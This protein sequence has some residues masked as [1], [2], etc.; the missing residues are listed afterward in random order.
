MSSLGRSHLGE[1]DLVPTLDK[2]FLSGA[3]PSRIRATR[4]RLYDF[5]D[6]FND[7]DHAAYAN[8]AVRQC[9]PG[10]G[11][12]TF[13]DDG[14][15]SFSV[16]G[17][18][19]VWPTPNTTGSG[20]NGDEAPRG[21]ASVARLAGKML[22]AKLRNT[23]SAT[24]TWDFGFFNNTT[25]A[26]GN[27][28][29][30][31]GSW[32]GNPAIWEAAGGGTSNRL[33]FTEFSLALNVEYE[34]AVVLRSAG[35]FY[36]IKGG[37]LFPDWTLLWIA[38]AASGSTLYHAFEPLNGAGS[39]DEWRVPKKLW[40][41]T[42]QYS[43]VPLADTVLPVALA[44]FIVD[45]NVSRNNTTPTGNGIDFF[46]RNSGGQSIRLFIEDDGDVLVTNTTTADTITFSAGIIPNTSAARVVRLM[47]N[48]ATVRAFVHAPGSPTWTAG[49]AVKTWT[50]NQTATQTYYF[51]NNA[52]AILTLNS[53]NVWKRTW[54][55]EFPNV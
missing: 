20:L 40:T 42:A 17:N 8:A 19:L 16:S 13:R 25:P 22:L 47:F 24:G 50:A 33:T 27:A 52:G 55:A 6:D 54:S 21:T 51:G 10:P 38:D 7:G 46:F 48:G 4:S 32:I 18:R 28:E 9:S 44:D 35:A 11:S 37:V 43:A 15:P 12:I 45:V 2:T 30:C 53:V 36:F 1:S 26:I 31:L 29:H 49:S 14:T 5:Y 34:C 39:C 41:P 3:K 23:A